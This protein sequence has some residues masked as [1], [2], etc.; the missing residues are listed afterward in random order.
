M[1]RY[2]RKVLNLLLTKLWYFQQV[3][4]HH[5]ISSRLLL[6]SLIIIYLGDRLLYETRNQQFSV[7]AMFGC[8]AFNCLVWLK[9]LT[10]RYLLC[11]LFLG[12]ILRKEQ[13]NE[14]LP[15]Y[16]PPTVLVILPRRLLHA[17]CNVSGNT[18]LYGIKQ[19]T[20]GIYGGN[21]H[22]LATNFI[23]FFDLLH[24]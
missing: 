20:L 12:S 2:L 1:I 16:F 23:A 13:L 8:G 9:K 5:R 14:R 22:R 19:P 6:Y 10:P 3:R 24:F 18:R 4:L 17:W 21:R 7:R 11:F 15:F